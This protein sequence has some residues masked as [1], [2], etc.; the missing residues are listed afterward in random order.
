ML[1]QKPI[2]IQ[3]GNTRIQVLHTY[4]KE[5]NNNVHRIVS[6]LR[7]F[8]LDHSFEVETWVI[9]KK[10]KSKTVTTLIPYWKKSCSFMELHRFLRAEIRRRVEVEEDTLTLNEKRGHIKRACTETWSF[11]GRRRRYTKR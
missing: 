8:N 2:Q 10:N 5:T 9:N 4:K 6:M 1:T 7:T 11:V 3:N